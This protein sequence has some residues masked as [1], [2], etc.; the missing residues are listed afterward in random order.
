MLREDGGGYRVHVS[1]KQTN[2][3]A[4][5]QLLIIDTWVTRVQCCY[6]RYQHSERKKEFSKMTFDRRRVWEYETFA[7]ATLHTQG[8]Q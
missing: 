3:Q 2:C 7:L 5:S 1:S 8:V 6:R 4:A